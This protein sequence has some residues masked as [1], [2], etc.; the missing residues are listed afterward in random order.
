MSELVYWPERGYGACEAFD[1]SIYDQDYFNHLVLESKKTCVQA[2]NLARIEFVERHATMPGIVSDVALCSLCDVG[3]GAMA[4]LQAMRERHG[5]L[6]RGYDEAVIAQT[7]LRNS[8]A[9]HDLVFRECVAATFWDSLEH[10]TEPG[11]TMLLRNVRR[12][13]FISTPIYETGDAIVT[14]KHFKKGEHLLYFTERGL[15]RWMSARCFELVERNRMEEAFGREGIGT[16][17]FER[18][19]PE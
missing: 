13:V 14:S 11:A 3:V 19:P 2:N 7:T 17:C 4:F 10:M 1:P 9:W 5:S 15:I 6:I 8:D 16:Y 12:H 18:V